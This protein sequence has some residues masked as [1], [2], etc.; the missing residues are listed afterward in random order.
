MGGIHDACTHPCM[1]MLC[2]CLVRC[3]QD[4]IESQ[5]SVL[6]KYGRDLTHL[7]REG[8]L[9]PLIGRNDEIRR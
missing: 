3:T 4:V 7:A 5:P 2:P 9:D 6:A 8:K 1:H